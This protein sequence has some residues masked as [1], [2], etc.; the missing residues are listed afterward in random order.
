MKIP[1][2]VEITRIDGMQKKNRNKN[3]GMDKNKKKVVN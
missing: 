1:S 3:S 2:S